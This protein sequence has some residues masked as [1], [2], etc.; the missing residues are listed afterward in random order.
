MQE[1]LISFQV[2]KLAKEKGFDWLCNGFYDLYYIPHNN[3]ITY[4]SPDNW[5][6]YK[7]LS[8][9]T[10][11]L[12]QKWLREVHN[13]HVEVAFH[14]FINDNFE[15]EKDSFKTPNDFKYTVEVNYY[16]KNMEIPQSDEEDFLGY[17]FDTYEEA[18][19]LGLFKAL[20]LI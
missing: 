9:P 14:S 11:T 18:F 2:A 8:A 7:S 1:Q 3:E 10:Q 12:L 5:N 4:S 19:E 13:C 20:E 15:P 6:L 16:G 17:N